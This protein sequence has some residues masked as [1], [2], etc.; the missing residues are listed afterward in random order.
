M[1]F[2]DFRNIFWDFL[3]FLRISGIHM[4]SLG[5]FRF[6]WDF[7]DFF[8]LFSISQKS[9]LEEHQ[10][11]CPFCETIVETEQHFLLECNTFGFHRT[12]FYTEIGEINPEF[13]ELDEEQKFCYLLRGTLFDSLFLVLFSGKKWVGRSETKKRKRKEKK[14]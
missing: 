3:D 10:R 12:Q 11:R 8:D 9:G 1:G 2:W 4:F 13:S 6:L 5:F 7:C 14:F